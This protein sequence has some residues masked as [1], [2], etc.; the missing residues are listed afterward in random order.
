[1]TSRMTLAF[2][3][4]GTLEDPHLAPLWEAGCTGMLEDGGEVVA[5]FS[6]PPPG[7]LLTR[8]P[9]GGRWERVDD[10][11]WVARYHETLAPVVVG[12]LVVAPTHREVT[13]RAPQRALWLD[14][15]MAFGTGHHETTYLALAALERLELRGR[16]VLDVGAGSGILA[17]AA[18]L[19]GAAEAEGLDIDPDTVGVAEANAALNAS[20]ARFSAGE[21]SARTRPAH[22]I[23][24]NL[25]AE[26]HAELAPLYARLLKPGGYLLATG[27]LASRG[28]VAQGALERVFGS[29]EVEARGEW[30]L[31][32]ARAP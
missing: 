26:L 23:V 17:I 25:Y 1:M 8:F 2:R 3:V 27:I 12:R 18:D 14:P 15:G 30:L 6:E 29:V 11:D 7:E 22:V 32:R 20:R 24:A 5:F 19:L 10:T 4:R 28:A 9:P 21:L 16:R 13:L 31:L